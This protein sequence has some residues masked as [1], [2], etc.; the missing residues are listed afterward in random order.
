MENFLI[1]VAFPIM[2]HTDKETKIYYNLIGV[3]YLAVNAS[4]HSP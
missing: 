2:E 4:V 1:N 3:P